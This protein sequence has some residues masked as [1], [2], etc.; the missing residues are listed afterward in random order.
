M[1]EAEQGSNATTEVPMMRAVLV[2]VSRSPQMLVAFNLGEGQ[3]LIMQIVGDDDGFDGLIVGTSLDPL[4]DVVDLFEGAGQHE[5]L[6]VRLPV[7]GDRLPAEDFVFH[8]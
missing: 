5:L 3:V 6:V 1:A 2:L 7:C 4:V 8:E